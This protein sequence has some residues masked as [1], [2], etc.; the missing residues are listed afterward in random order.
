[1]LVPLWQPASDILCMLVLMLCFE[2]N[3]Y[4]DDDD[5]HTVRTMKTV[6][7]ALNTNT[8]R[9]SSIRS[10]E[11]H[12]GNSNTPSLAIIISN[13]RFPQADLSE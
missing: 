6:K 2:A 7:A 3:K 8:R 1:M 12:V 9:T 13:S 10:R 5:R 4:D 11:N